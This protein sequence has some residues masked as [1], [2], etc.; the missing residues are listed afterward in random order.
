MAAGLYITMAMDNRQRNK[1]ARS[2]VEVVGNEEGFA[3]FTDNE[4]KAFRYRL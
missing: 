1:N 4:N 3:D 2:V